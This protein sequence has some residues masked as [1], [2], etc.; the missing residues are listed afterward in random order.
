MNDMLE[1]TELPDRYYRPSGAIPVMGTLTMLFGG[2]AA[3]VIL[4]FIVALVNRYFP[5]VIALLAVT[6]GYGAGVGAAVRFSA[7]IAHVRHPGFTR[8]VAFVVG[9]FAVYA[10]WVWYLWVHTKPDFNVLRQAFI[11]M[12][13]FTQ[14]GKIVDVMQFIAANGAWTAFGW[15]PKGGMLY[16]IWTLEALMYVFFSVALAVNPAL[17]YCEACR[18]WTKRNEKLAHMPLAD[19]AALKTELEGERYD[20]LDELRSQPCDMNNRLDIGTATCPYCAETSFLTVSHVKVS[21]DGNGN[22]TENST[23]V[24]QHLIVPREIADRMA[25]PVTPMPAAQVQPPAPAE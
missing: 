4:G 16:T 1:L 10:A 9:L 23:P 11:V 5:Y 15:T 14:P 6:I 19:F 2:M 20:V 7:K 13:W 12:Q 17:T 8:F 25:I 21:T 18:C 22:P 3:S 24:V